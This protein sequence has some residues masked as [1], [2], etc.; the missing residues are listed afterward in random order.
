M[1]K[2]KTI[3]L[4]LLPA[5]LFLLAGCGGKGA[6]QETFDATADLY[7][8]GI[9]ETSEEAAAVDMGASMEYADSPEAAKESAAPTP[10]VTKN[11]LS[12]RKLIRTI[13]LSM[14][15]RRF[16]VLK[17]QMEETISACGGYIENSDLHA[18]HG[19]R[20]YRSYSLTVRIPTDKLDNFMEKAGQ[21]GTITNQS[22]N[23][24]DVTLDYVDK[25]AYKES[26]ETE[27]K[28][29]NELLEKAE[30]LEQV[31][32]LESKLS[33]LRYEINSY[34]SQLRTYDNLIDYS[35]VHIQ[36][37]E[38]EYEE[39]APDTIGSRIS[40]GFSH[41]LYAVRNFFVDLFVV[42]VS[43]LPTLVLLA[44]FLCILLLLLKKL[45]KNRAKRR[46]Q[47]LQE[48]TQNETLEKEDAPGK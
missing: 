46:L 27:Y 19:E 14:E 40:N 21:L 37:S 47:R 23:V 18:P 3:S 42:L 29:V 32:A 2:K 34:E 10:D 6:A 15:T 26:L 31:L 30:D 48:E 45:V 20:Q 17:S 7:D 43:S 1:K 22:E 13:Y 28:R 4:L 35:T 39:K 44:A 41:N 12:A 24:E 36:I 16:D 38:V 9:T 5:L 8:G 11:D 33:S 25:T